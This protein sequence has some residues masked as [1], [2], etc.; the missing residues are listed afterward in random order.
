MIFTPTY[1]L[2]VR[3][4]V[5]RTICSA[6]VRGK[7]SSALRS[8]NENPHYTAWHF[9]ERYSAIPHKHINKLCQ[10]YIVCMVNNEERCYIMQ[11]MVKFYKLP[12][13]SVTIIDAE[14]V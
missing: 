9:A 4:Y 14:D 2:E 11:K 10:V 6:E 7:P 5:I 3:M 1:K 8:S 12:S 13:S